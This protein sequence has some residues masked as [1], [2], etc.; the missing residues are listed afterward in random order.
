MEAVWQC[1]SVAVDGSGSCSR[2]CNRGRI[3]PARGRSASGFGFTSW[4]SH[5][6]SAQPWIMA[7]GTWRLAPGTSH[8]RRPE[9]RHSSKAR[10]ASIFWKLERVRVKESRQ[11]ASPP[12]PRPSDNSA[13]PVPLAHIAHLAHI[14]QIWGKTDRG[15]K[16]LGPA[17]AVGA[18]C[19]FP[20]AAS[21]GRGSDGILVVL[22]PAGSPT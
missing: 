2:T 17:G 11:G 5:G 12:E 15:A 13:V 7:P 20:P 8:E 19:A 16:L 14:A 1:G 6:S 9:T 21:R 3:Q 18:S 22:T 10:T 4:L